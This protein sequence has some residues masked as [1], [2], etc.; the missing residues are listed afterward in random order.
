MLSAAS[1]RSRRGSRAKLTSQRSP[2]ASPAI[3]S[4]QNTSI[5]SIIMRPQTLHMPHIPHIGWEAHPF[6]S[7]SGAG[8]SAC[9]V[10]PASAANA[11]PGARVIRGPSGGRRRRRA[12]ARG[13]AQRGEIGCKLFHLAAGEVLELL[14]VN[15]QLV[16]GRG[17]EPARE[18]VLVV[19]GPH[20]GEVGAGRVAGT[21]DRMAAETAVVDEELL[22]VREQQLPFLRAGRQDGQQ[23]AQP[24]SGDT[25]L[26]AR[27]PFR[28]RFA[29]RSTPAAGHH[30][31]LR[32]RYQGRAG[33]GGPRYP[34]MP[35]IGTSD[36][37]RRERPS[38]SRTSTTEA[39]S[40]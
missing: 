31:A 9:G 4:P 23:K 26:H 10:P 8:A 20:V 38:R 27:V 2:T 37:T 28:S 34:L 39:R 24:D 6:Q 25:E 30:A 15:R 17:A 40:L 5:R 1:A 7:R 16:P 13:S 11:I 29:R 35:P 33:A 3:T 19:P 22:A 32:R 36:A 14:R 18:P 12:P 21:A